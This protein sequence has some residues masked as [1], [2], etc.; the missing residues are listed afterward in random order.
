MTTDPKIVGYIRSL[1]EKHPKLGKEKIKPLLDEYCLKVNISSI[2]TSTIG[3]VVK[4]HNLFFAS[5]GRIYHNPASLWAQKRLKRK[6]RLRVRYCPKPKDF[7]HFQLDS[8]VKFSQ[9]LKRYLITAI[10]IKLK[11]SFSFCY[12]GLNS[13][14]GK[15]F[16]KKLETVYPLAIKSIQTDNG[17]E[18]LGECDKYLE[19]KSIPHYF[20]YPRCPKINGV[21]ERFNRTIKEE[22]VNNN[23]E[24]LHDTK[25][26]NQKMVEYLIFYN[27][28]RVHKSLGLKTPMDYLIEKGSMSKKCVTYTGSWPNLL[29]DNLKN[30]DIV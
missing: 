4:R 9:G 23:L 6:K 25:L 5:Q 29:F 17:L 26:F 16:I 28:K 11:F 20:T 1:R 13:L 7:G 24:Y 3:K 30:C 21:V 8:T 14:N 15:D 2:S 12:K 18:F 10:D 22:F 27:T 19:A